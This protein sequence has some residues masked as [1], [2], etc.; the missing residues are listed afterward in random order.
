MRHGRRKPYTQIGIA[1]IPCVRCGEKA[2]HQWQV[3]ADNR[4]YRPLCLSCDFKLNRLVLKWAN[5][6]DWKEK[7][8]AY[9]QSQ[10]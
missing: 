2:H 7:C 6:P 5:D 8:E 4:I 10:P 1:R 3:C 9:E